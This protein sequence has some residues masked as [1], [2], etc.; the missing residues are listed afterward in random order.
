MREIL[1]DSGHGFA[2]FVGF[3][4]DISIKECFDDDAHG[5]VGHLSIDVNTTTTGP[6]LLDL[7]GISAHGVCIAG[8]M[9]RLER[10]SH[11]LALVTMKISITRSKASTQD[12][13]EDCTDSDA[14]VEVIGMVDQNAL[15][16][17]WFIKQDT[18]ER[19]KMDVA[20]VSF[21]CQTP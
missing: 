6:S 4:E 11:E 10:G 15:H 16:V 5:Q 14:F 19:P 13:A 20:N 8:N 21:M 12:R 17:L 7:L 3:G 9:T 1:C 18:R 2:E